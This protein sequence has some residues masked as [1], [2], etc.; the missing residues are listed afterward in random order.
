MLPQRCF[1]YANTTCKCK[2]ESVM[3]EFLCVD[4]KVTNDKML[5]H[6]EDN[7]Q[8]MTYTN[9]NAELSYHGQH[10]NTNTNTFSIQILFG[11]HQWST[12][13]TSLRK[14]NMDVGEPIHCIRHRQ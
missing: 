1:V 7:I 12:M 10:T 4:L 9:T 13:Y 2:T 11:W 14:F 3:S 5:N 6:S 8:C